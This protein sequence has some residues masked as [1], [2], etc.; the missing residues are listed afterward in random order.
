MEIYHGGY[1]ESDLDGTKKY[2]VPS[3]VKT[4]GKVYLDGLDEKEFSWVE[5]NNIAYALGYRE[6]PIS[7]HFK[8]PRTPANVGWIQIN[9]EGEAREM[10]NMIPKKKRD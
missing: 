9:C 8:Q 4:W 3:F 7:Y 2:K 1:F 6:L 5:M 10:V